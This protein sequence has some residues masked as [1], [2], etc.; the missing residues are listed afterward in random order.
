VEDQ[1]KIE[2]VLRELDQSCPLCRSPKG[3]YQ[4][5]FGPDSILRTCDTHLLEVKQ[6]V[7]NQLPTPSISF[8]NKLQ[9]K[10]Y[11]RGLE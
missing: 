9:D 7:I 3:W 4:F 10:I 8:I 11:H 1:T 5:F 2:D 6:K